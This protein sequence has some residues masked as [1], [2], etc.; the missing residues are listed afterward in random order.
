MAS[1]YLFWSSSSCDD[2][3][4]AAETQPSQP[5]AKPRTRK[6]A[7]PAAPKRPPQRGLGVAQLERLRLQERWKKMTESDAGRDIQPIQ[8]VQIHHAPFPYPGYWCQSPSPSPAAPIGYIP[9]C[10][11][12]NLGFGSVLHDHYSMDRWRMGSTTPGIALSEPPSNQRILPQCFSDQCEF[13]A[14]KKRLFGEDRLFNGGNGV[15]YFEM[16]LAASM[17]VDQKGDGIGCYERKGKSTSEMEREVK[18]FEFFPPSV[19]AF[20]GDSEI[21]GNRTVGDASSSSSSASPIL[22]DLSLRLS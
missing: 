1:T 16:D 3:A 20:R 22:L 2:G 13:C 12:T 4:A 11:P 14:R 18:E 6:A 9:R 7:K 15:D 5:A 19:S 8:P 10:R 17:A 21:G